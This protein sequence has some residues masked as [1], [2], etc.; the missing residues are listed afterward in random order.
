MIRGTYGKHV[1]SRE[2]C[3]RRNVRFEIKIGRPYTR[4]CYPAEDLSARP[5]A[6]M[7]I[8]LVRDISANAKIESTVYITRTEIS[9]ALVA[10]TGGN[11]R[12][13]VPVRYVYVRRRPRETSL[14]SPSLE[15]CRTKTCVCSYYEYTMYYNSGISAQKKKKKKKKR[16]EK[17]LHFSDADRY[18]VT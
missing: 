15:K 11:D 6:S 12:R 9:R 5:K 18:R 2:Y 8:T 3:T 13:V 17:S 10:C 16:K 1:R 7:E 14:F 4:T